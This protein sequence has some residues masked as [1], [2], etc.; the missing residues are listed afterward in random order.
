MSDAA[1]D[2]ALRDLGAHLAWPQESDLA[3]RVVAELENVV[4]LRPRSRARRA[5]LVAAAALLVLTALLAVSPGL[6]AAFYRLLGIRGAAVEVH[7]TVAPPGGPS[8]VDEALLGDPVPQSDAEGEIGF[9]L[10]FPS[11]LGRPEG[12]YVLRGGASPIA[13]V[14]Y[15]DERL[16]LSQFRGRLEEATIGKS[17]VAGQAEFVDVGGA[18]GIWVEGPH[19]VFVRDPSGAIVDSRSFLGENT[20]LWSV[21]GVTF[22]L[23][24]AVELGDA[25][26]IARTVAL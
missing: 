23:E 22:R 8:F 16:I 10:A 25:L 6:R 20:L 4:P 17:V 13:T 5:V 26:R 7:E 14:T 1:L 9:R 18:E 19:A 15:G 12:V 11:G 21:G 2:L 24:G 3:P